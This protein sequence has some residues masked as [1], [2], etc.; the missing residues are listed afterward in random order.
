MFLFEHLASGHVALHTGDCRASA[1][2]REAVLGELRASRPHR[3]HPLVASPPSCREAYSSG[4]AS[5]SGEASSSGVASSEGVTSSAGVGSNSGEAV[6]ATPFQA[7]RKRPLE[8]AERPCPP[9]AA[10][11][12]AAASAT[13]AASGV[14]DAE[15]SACGARSASGSVTSGL[16]T[17]LPKQESYTDK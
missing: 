5:S 2:V 15:G 3:D 11:A 16:R 7:R 17:W 1:S 6:G 9:A 12:A 14:A 13:A 8:A 4:L 10:A